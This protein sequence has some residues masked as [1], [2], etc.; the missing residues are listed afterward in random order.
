MPFN[1]SGMVTIAYLSNGGNTATATAPAGTSAKAVAKDAMLLSVGAPPPPGVPGWGEFPDTCPLCWKLNSGIII[2]IPTMAVP[3]APPAGAT[4]S[5][6]N[7]STG[8]CVV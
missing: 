1:G 3:S 2:T 6:I 5:P 7:S 8:A 4:T